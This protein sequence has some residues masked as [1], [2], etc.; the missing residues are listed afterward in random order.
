MAHNYGLHHAG[1]RDQS[2]NWVEY[3][4]ASSVSMVFVCVLLFLFDS[5]NSGICV[6]RELG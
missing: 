2:G 5:W 4:D 6:S 3:G 1:A